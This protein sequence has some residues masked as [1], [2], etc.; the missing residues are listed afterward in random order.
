MR[1]RTARRQ[2]PLAAAALF[3]TTLLLSPQGKGASP[4]D[5]HANIVNGR[6]TSGCPAAGDLLM[7]EDPAGAVT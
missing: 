5:F 1:A 4:E 7:S 3:T 2:L 6:P